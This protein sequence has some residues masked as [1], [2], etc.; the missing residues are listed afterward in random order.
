MGY[1]S[2]SVG[3]AVALIFSAATWTESEL[4]FDFRKNFRHTGEL[5]DGFMWDN[6]LRLPFSFSHSQSRIG[7][8]NGNYLDIAAKAKTALHYR[9]G[10]H[11]WS[12]SAFVGQSYSMIPTIK[13]RL[14]KTQDLLRVESRYLY[15]VLPWLSPFAHARMET[16]LF[17]G[18][19]TD[20]ADNDYEIYNQD[21]TL[22]EKR[23]TKEVHLAD[24]FRPLFF[25][26]NV[27]VAFGIVQNTEFNWEARANASFR[28]TIADHQLIFMEERD[29]IRILRKLKSFYEIGP[30]VAT[31]IG[32]QLFDDKVE[33]AA[34]FETMWPLWRSPASPD[35]DFWRSLNLE[36]S[37]G[38]TLNLNSWS[39]LGYEYSAA[40]I[41]DILPKFQQTH[42]LAFN[43]SFDWAYKF[44]Q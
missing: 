10:L 31:A 33:Y 8:N 41:P 4:S 11:D 25:Q 27:G 7:V 44:G 39:S 42:S 36:G 34:G 24:P 3:M 17:K 30:A 23:T 21:D 18:F 35:R 26:E 15:N 43:L 12:S 16:S 29:N 2:L 22:A 32:G 20:S 13:K 6:A 28:Q 9:N 5:P 40:R 14:L 37:A 1:K 38:I 19:D